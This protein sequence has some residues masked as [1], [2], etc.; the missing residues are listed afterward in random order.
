MPRIKFNATIAPIEPPPA[1]TYL[2]EVTKSEVK[3][4]AK[5]NEYIEAQFKVI[6]D[7]NM[8]NSDG[9]ESPIGGKVMFDNFS[10][11]PQSG[12]ALKDFMDAADIPHT[13]TPTAV[14]GEFEFDFDTKDWVGARVMAQTKV[15]GYVKADGK[16]GTRAEIEKYYPVSK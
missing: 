1:D 14:K 5:K 4:S 8:T 3:T 13:A 12:F 7:K 15:V 9:T 11:L 10:L 6:S 16:N 2:L